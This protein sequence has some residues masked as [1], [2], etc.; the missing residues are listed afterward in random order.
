MPLSDVTISRH[1]LRTA[2]EKE[3]MKK[4]IS[5]TLGDGSKSNKKSS[6]GIRDLMK[7]CYAEVAY[8]YVWKVEGGDEHCYISVER[9][10]ILSFLSREVHYKLDSR[11]DMV[12]RGGNL[13]KALCLA[14]VVHARL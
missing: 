5:E 2:A 9:K 7:R 6:G 3:Q 11:G 12:I 10:G 13:G 1:Y 14:D 4:R 8:V